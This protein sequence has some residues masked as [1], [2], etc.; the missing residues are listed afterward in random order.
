MRET[1]PVAAVGGAILVVFSTILWLEQRDSRLDDIAGNVLIM[2]LY[3]GFFVALVAGIGVFL[4][5]LSPG[6]HTFWRSRPVNVDQWFWTK[7]FIGFTV[8]V[9]VMGGLAVPS[10]V[11]G[12]FTGRLHDTYIWSANSPLFWA[13]A[14]QVLTYCGAVAAVCLVRQPL[15][16]AVLALCPWVVFFLLTVKWELIPQ[17]PTAMGIL[18]TVMSVLC[19]LTGWQA[20]RWDIGWK[21]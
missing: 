21:R 20:L 18:I 10:L 8:P 12:L 7:L 3:C 6:L 11:L 2:W 17:T 5:D 4:E 15:Y 1:L 16:A 14:I 9:V 13:P 19:A